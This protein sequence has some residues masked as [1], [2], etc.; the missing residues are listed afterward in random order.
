VV[1]VELGLDELLPLGHLGV[2][3]ADNVVD[4]LGIVFDFAWQQQEWQVMNSERA[5]GVTRGLC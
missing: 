5:R 4:F 1:V 3:L 2:E